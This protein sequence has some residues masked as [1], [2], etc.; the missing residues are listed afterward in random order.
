M[1]NHVFQK[2][3]KEN[4]RLLLTVQHNVTINLG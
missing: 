2:Q 3:L 4:T 1:D